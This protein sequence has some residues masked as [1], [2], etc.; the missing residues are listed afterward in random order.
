[1]DDQVKD[2]DDGKERVRE[3]IIKNK[4]TG[5]EEKV[6]VSIHSV[7]KVKVGSEVE[8]GA[9]LTTGLSNVKEILRCAGLNT[10]IKYLYKEIQ[11]VYRSQGIEISDKYIEIILKQMSSKVI[12]SNAGDSNRAIGE[13][14]DIET[15]RKEN[16]ALIAA[17][18][19]PI[20]A[21]NTILG[22]EDVPNKG[23]SFLSAASFLDTKSVLA[24]AAIRG[25]VDSFY[26]LKENVMI[27]GLI[28]AGTGKKSSEE[29]IKTGQEMYKKE[30]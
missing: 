12:I 4:Y 27:G 16:S 10:A 13:Y 11:K 24:T 3:L 26:G 20:I 9:Q 18:K 15:L 17:K 30:Y 21:F 28:P 7:L 1:M 22:L 5:K 2:S 14:L 23:D 29:V 8:C 19:A 6:D 25:S